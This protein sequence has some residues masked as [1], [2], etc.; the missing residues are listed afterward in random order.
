MRRHGILVGVALA[1]SLLVAAPASA[2]HDGDRYGH[3]GYDNGDCE[4]SGDCGG[5][6]YDQ[7]YGS[8]D[9]RNRNRHRNRGAFSPGPFD[10]SPVIITICP[11]GTQNCGPGSGQD[12]PP[13]EERER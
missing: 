5:Q 10:H 7:N 8:R 2:Y 6:N 11:P 9:D 4:W 12:Q 1:A 3:G 13:P